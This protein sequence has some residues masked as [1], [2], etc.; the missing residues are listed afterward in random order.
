MACGFYVDSAGVLHPLGECSTQR[1]EDFKGSLGFLTGSGGAVRESYESYAGE[2]SKF[3]DPPAR[4]TAEE[5]RKLTKAQAEPSGKIQPSRP[6]LI[7][8][9]PSA[10]PAPDPAMQQADAGKIGWIVG[11]ALLVFLLFGRK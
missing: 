2:R 5:A 7:S 4:R 9:E 1:V 6:P 8:V 11:A 10:V 3:I